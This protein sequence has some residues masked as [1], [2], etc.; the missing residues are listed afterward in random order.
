MTTAIKQATTFLT[1]ADCLR[2]VIGYQCSV[3]VMNTGTGD[4]PFPISVVVP[5]PSD[6]SIRKLVWKL[7]GPEYAVLSWNAGDTP[8]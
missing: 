8:F 5:C 4:R 1:H 3:L 7:K 2:G 6:T